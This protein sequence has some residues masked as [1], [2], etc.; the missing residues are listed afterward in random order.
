MGVVKTTRC[1]ALRAVQP[2]LEKLDCRGAYIEAGKIQS[3]IGLRWVRQFLALRRDL[4]LMRN[5]AFSVE[6][7][8]SRQ[9]ITEE[10]W[11]T[12]S[13]SWT[14][15]WKVEARRSHFLGWKQKTCLSQWRSVMSRNRLLDEQRR[16]W[17]CARRRFGFDLWGSS[18]AS[19]S[20]WLPLHGWA[21]LASSSWGRREWKRL[22][23]RRLRQRPCSLS[24]DEVSWTSAAGQKDSRTIWTVFYFCQEKNFTRYL[25]QRTAFL[26]LFWGFQLF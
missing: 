6:L 3:N 26:M 11:T 2:T 24:M 9:G 16:G 21:D 13:I 14:E 5:S 19:R 20:S 4:T 23:R 18:R 22:T 15:R 17:S 25:S 10:K 8:D 1:A 7:L 12:W